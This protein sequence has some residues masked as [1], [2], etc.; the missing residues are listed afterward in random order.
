MEK[1]RVLFLIVIRLLKNFI[2]GECGHLFLVCK[3]KPDTKEQ[4]KDSKSYM[5]MYSDTQFKWSICDVEMQACGGHTRNIIPWDLFV[6]N[7]CVIL[8]TLQNILQGKNYHVHFRDGEAGVY[9]QLAKQHTQ[10]IVEIWI[11]VSDIHSPYS[12]LHCS[13]TQHSNIT[14]NSVRH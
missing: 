4:L 6:P 11:E 10:E 7:I 3:G 12:T 8:F 13:A 5:S 14:I 1:E 9:E 2:L